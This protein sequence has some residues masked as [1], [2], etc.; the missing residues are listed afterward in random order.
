MAAF[1]L[2]QLEVFFAIA[3]NRSVSGASRQLFI[4]QSSL[5]KTLNRLEENLDIH[6]F[7]RNATG[8]V[9]TQEGSVLYHRLKTAYQMMNRAIED[10]R[11]AQAGNI[12]TLH[13]GIHASCERSKEFES[14]WNVLDAFEK[15]NHSIS[16]DE[17]LLE[18][19][20]LNSKLLTGQLDAIITH[21][22][23]LPTAQPLDLCKLKLLRFSIAMAAN[24]PLAAKE[25][26]DL[27]ELNGEVFYYVNHDGTT[28]EAEFCRQTLHTAGIAEPVVVPMPNIRSAAKAVV[29]GRGM[30]LTCHSHGYSSE[31]IRLF[32][33]TNPRV[34][35]YLVCACLAEPQK[36]E[37]VSFMSYMS[38]ADFD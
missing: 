27:K 12:R 3:E 17:V 16:V 14:V 6:L 28:Q 37:L 11:F 15:A 33:A 19:E 38:S 9:L 1:T 30:M 34:P 13:V 24:H 23:T 4:S 25:P 26:I 7:D 21:S 2:Q 10:A 32:S 20:E 31:E 8:V 5:S 35:P 36:P 18:Y 22:F 29:R